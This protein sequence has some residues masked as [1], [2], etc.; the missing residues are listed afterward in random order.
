[1]LFRLLF[2]LLIML[3]PF[4][5]AEEGFC[6]SGGFRNGYS[7]EVPLFS[8]LDSRN[9]SFSIQLLELGD[10]RKLSALEQVVHVSELEGN[11]RLVYLGE[12]DS[13]ASGMAALQKTLKNYG[14]DHY[15]ML[16]ALTPSDKMP[17]IRLVAEPNVARPLA[18]IP[19][20]HSEVYAIQ[21]AAFS[22]AQDA[23]Q[24]SEQLLVSGLLCRRK[25]NGLYAVYYQKYKSLEQASSH[26]SDHSFIEELGGYVV[27]LNNVAFGACVDIDTHEGSTPRFIAEDTRHKSDAVS[28]DETVSNHTVL[29]SEPVASLKPEPELKPDVEPETMSVSRN[30]YDL[31]YTIQLAAFKQ[32]RSAARFVKTHSKQPLLCRVKDN[33]MSAIY[34]GQY[35]SAA[36]AHAHTNDFPLIERQKGYVVKLK[37]VAFQSCQ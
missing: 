36:Q 35:S 1:M 15:P 2:P 17:R 6:L 5:H 10:D 27:A 20:T 11:K 25:N 26:L 30:D 33:G 18:I 14:V 8:E 28:V 4:S 32:K 7:C 19:T 13:Q 16:V 34:Y 37:N 24:F 23:K 21:L 31:I 12:Y 29:A 3:T 9:T 22:S